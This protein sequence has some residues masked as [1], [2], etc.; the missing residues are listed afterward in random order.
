[1]LDLPKQCPNIKE[2][3][4]IEG[5]CFVLKQVRNAWNLL[6]MNAKHMTLD[7]IKVLKIITHRKIIFLPYHGYTY[8]LII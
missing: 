2:D 6:N 4:K 7:Y 3:K 5:V 1:M 8:N